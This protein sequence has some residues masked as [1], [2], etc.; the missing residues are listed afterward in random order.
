VIPDLAFHNR[1]V[2]PVTD[3]KLVADRL[4]SLLPRTRDFS[5]LGSTLAFASRN[6]EVKINGMTLVAVSHTPYRLDRSDCQLPEIWVPLQGHMVAFDGETRYR[7]GV[8][9]AYFCASQR[10]DIETSSVSVV[11]FR[12]DMHRLNAVHAAMAGAPSPSPIPLQTR[13]LQ[14]DVNGVNFTRLFLNALRQV[15]ALQSHP[16]VL[17]KLGID[18]V[19]YRLLVGLLRPQMLL[20]AEASERTIGRSHKP[21]AGLCD[22]LQANLTKPIASSHMEQISGL[23]ARSLQYAFQ[24][25]HGMRPKEW[26][27]KQ[28]LHAARTMLLKPDQA[29]RITTLAYEFCFASPSAFSQAYQMEFGES[30]SETLARKRAALRP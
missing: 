16:E 26:L 2:R 3:A 29:I 13:T 24:K 8:D 20:A 10:R 12:F 18:D 23:S 7:Y 25:T 19:F 4:A 5:V 9:T 11:G 27:R 28:R 6:A 21:I 30:P 22:F 14:L 15:D 17:E 1:S